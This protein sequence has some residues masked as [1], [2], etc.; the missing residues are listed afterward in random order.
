LKQNIF[1]DFLDLL[2]FEEE[3]E[4]FSEMLEMGLLRAESVKML[5]DN[6]EN[7]E[8]K[9]SVETLIPRIGKEDY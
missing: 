4:S 8:L 9:Y 6:Y 7:N 2:G 1:L 3:M 5:C